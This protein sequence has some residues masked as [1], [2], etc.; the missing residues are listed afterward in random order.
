V[1]FKAENIIS[2][3]KPLELLLLDLFGPSRTKTLGG[4]YYDFV[5]VNNFHRFIWALFLS[6]KDDTFDAF[7]KFAQVISLRSEHGGEF[8]NHQF[9]EFCDEFGISHNL[10]CSGTPQQN[11]VV[12]RKLLYLYSPPLARVLI[13][14]IDQHKENAIV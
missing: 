13:G 7:A 3:S 12:K 11:R 8:V 10:S 9:E 5:I 6:S 1:S 4:N 2:T 14:Q